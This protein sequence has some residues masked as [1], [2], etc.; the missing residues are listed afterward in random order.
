MLVVPEADITKGL[1]YQFFGYPSFQRTFG[2][3]YPATESYQASGPWQAGLAN[4]ANCG[5]IIGGFA[6]GFLS[7]RYGYKRVCLASLF[8]MNW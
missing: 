5:I 3:W 6:N 1:I 2:N 7:Q 4:G 8:F